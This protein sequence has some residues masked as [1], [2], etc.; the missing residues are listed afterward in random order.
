LNQLLNEFVDAGGQAIELAYPNIEPQLNRWLT[1]QALEKGL[2][3]SQGSDFH[4]PQWVWVKPGYF[5]PLPKA[6][7][8]VWEL[9]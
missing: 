5:P 3:A 1:E 6:I 2:Y 4:N 7:P 8:P 9:W